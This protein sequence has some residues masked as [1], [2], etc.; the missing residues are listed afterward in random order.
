MNRREFLH[1]TSAMTLTAGLLPTIP[2]IGGTSSGGVAEVRPIARI[3]RF[4]AKKVFLDSWAT[5]I[6]RWDS[7][8]AAS[9]I[10]DRL[11]AI[12]ND[13]CN[14]LILVP[15]RCASA[16]WLKQIETEAGHLEL[17]VL[18]PTQL[19]SDFFDKA[20]TVVP[21]AHGEEIF[22]SCDRRTAN[23][24]GFL[25][26]NAADNVFGLVLY[27]TSRCRWTGFVSSDVGFARESI[28]QNAESCELNSKL[29]AARWLDLARQ[30]FS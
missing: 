21:L 3:V 8:H 7:F 13:G 23:E 17:T 2:V 25:L 12:R 30:S 29:T 15:G 26:L 5:E 22:Q 10:Q 1:A 11:N 20:Q 24:G 14:G 9:L 16:E 6:V 28:E 4:R 19:T 18:V 27:D